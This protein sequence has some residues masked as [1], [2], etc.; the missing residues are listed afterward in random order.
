MGKKENWVFSQ[1]YYNK[2]IVIKEFATSSR[3]ELMQCIYGLRLEINNLQQLIDKQKAEEVKL[4][5]KKI[6]ASDYKQEWSYP[7][8]LFFLISFFDKPMTSLE[9]HKQL[10]QFDKYFKAL[11]RP[12]TTLS[13]ILNRSCTTGRIAKYKVKGIKELL[14]VLPKWLDKSG[15][16]HEKYS[17]QIK[18]F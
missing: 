11:Q 13:S 12:T 17:E 14:F 2:Q 6:V 5:I 18:L 1:S 3:E 15:E 7:T 16:L 8:K 9:L 10:R 4:S